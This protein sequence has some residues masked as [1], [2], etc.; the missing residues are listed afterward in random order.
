MFNS[1]GRLIILLSIFSGSIIQSNSGGIIED[2]RL[3]SFKRNNFSNLNQSKSLQPVTDD[4]SI[5]EEE[6][7]RTFTDEQDFDF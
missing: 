1:F 6:Q 3:K 7:E 5:I 2:G 4:P